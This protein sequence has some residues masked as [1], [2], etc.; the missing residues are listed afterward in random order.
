[1]AYQNSRNNNRRSNRRKRNGQNSDTTSQQKSKP[2]REERAKQ[3]ATHTKRMAAIFAS[4]IR[5][6][7]D[8]TKRY[9]SDMMTDL[10]HE[11]NPDMHVGMIALGTAQAASK[12]A[13]YGGKTA[14]L[15][16]ASFKNPGGGYMGGSLAQEEA[17]CTESN[18]YN[19]LSQHQDWYDENKSMRADDE[20]RNALYA[21]RGLYVPDVALT[22]NNRIVKCDVIVVAA[23]NW[24][25]A[26]KAGCDKA[27]NDEALSK[28]IDL[29]LDMA[30]DNG[31]K[32]IV[33]GAFGC[34]VFGQDPRQ[35]ASMFKE[36]LT[37][38][39]FANVVFA[40]LPGRGGDVRNVKAFLDE[41][42]E[43]RI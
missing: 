29:V 40:V 8:G 25:A 9:T 13:Q 30:E 2:N 38:R 5:K 18:L 34:G 3:A 16:F 26:S 21:D 22:V 33:L 24:C 31:V 23:P 42:G 11:P 27:A 10:K 32:S 36:K 37:N 20:S 15:D 19:I 28:R 39:P 17:I 12:L 43:I 7:V 41:F 14:L 6:S 1:M 35:V 4:D